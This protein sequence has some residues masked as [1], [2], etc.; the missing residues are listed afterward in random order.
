MTSLIKAIEKDIPL[1][2]ELAEKSWKSAYAELLSKEQI[3]YMLAEMYSVEEISA[4]LQNR[5][6]HYYLI[7]NENI[8]VGFIGFEHH[9]ELQTTK[10]HRIYLVENAKGKGCGKTALNF[11]KKQTSESGDSRIILNVN[12]E[13]NAKSIYE[14]QGFSVY[15][16]DVFD[17][18]NGFVMDDY[19]MEFIL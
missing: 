10:L 6:Y 9:Y 5:N 4:H 15:K 13:N 1:I 16:E 19:L 7:L 11:L 17:I 2:R 12:K 18:G 3:D 8:A 14:S